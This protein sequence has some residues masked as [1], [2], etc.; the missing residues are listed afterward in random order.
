MRRSKGD[1]EKRVDRLFVLGLRFN[2]QEM[3]K[4]DFNVHH[5]EIT[6]DTDKEFDA[7]VE[8]IKAE[9]ERREKES[10]T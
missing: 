1:F 2:G 7:K 9:M 8:K 10:A 3:C 5:T 4:E 6:C